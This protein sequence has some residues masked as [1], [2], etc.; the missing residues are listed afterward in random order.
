[1]PKERFELPTFS[2]QVSCTANCAI[3]AWAN[4][5]GFAPTSR[6]IRPMFQL[7]IRLI[8]SIYSETVILAMA[9]TRSHNISIVLLLSYLRHICHM[10]VHAIWTFF[11]SFTFFIRADV[12]SF[13]VP[14]ASWNRRTHFTS[15]SLGGI[16]N[17]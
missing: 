11:I 12:A 17:S 5:V 9:E 10:V 16:L 14:V 4:R 1:M 7:N 6:L 13:N 3:W 2:L 15:A 8:I